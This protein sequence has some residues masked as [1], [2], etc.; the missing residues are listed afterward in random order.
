M[1]AL[2]ILRENWKPALTVTAVNVPLSISLAVASG[3]T[4]T[5]GIITGIWSTV[6]A[7]A[8]ASSRH[9]VFGVAGAL[10]SILLAFVLSHGSDGVALLPVLS[11]VSGLLI[12]LVSL[13]KLTRYVTLIPSTVLHGF[14]ISVGI[15]IALSQIS[16]A[17][18]LNDPALGIP[19][20]KEILLNLA[21]AFSH[22]GDSN[23]AAVATFAASLA[24][25]VAAKR[26]APAF[27][28]VVALTVA[29]IGA[30]MAFSKGMLPGDVLLL[31]EK[32]PDVAF[33]PF[34]FPFGTLGV[35]SFYGA[36]VLMKSVSSTAVVIAVVAILETVISA[37]IAEKM[38]RKKFD[39]DRE[40]LGL[41]LS[42]VGTG[43]LGGLPVTA[44]FIRTALNL[45]S[46][47]THR[48]SQ[49]LV[50]L[51]TFLAA[52]LLFE[53]FFQ[54]LPFPIIA[55]I[56]F[57][58]ALGLIDFSLLAKM[59]RMRRFAFAVMALTT[60]VSVLEDPTVGILLGTS[61]ALLAFIRGV[62]AGDAYVSVFRKGEF[63]R[64]TSL[65]DYV[66]DQTADDVIVVNFVGGLSYLNVEPL[67]ESVSRVDAGQTVLISFSHM[68]DLDVDGVEG[69]EE[70]V[71]SLE[72]HS[73]TVYFTGVTEKTR[74]PLAKAR[75]FLEM[76][77]D[78]RI[79][80]S[81]SSALADI[82]KPA[83]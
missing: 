53:G 21:E 51:F 54:Y 77:A 34:Q 12:L 81:T 38:T 41:G 73:V 48:A 64:K 11:I 14:L 23:P 25:L 58:I 39:R 63:H 44:V 28:S 22:L 18:G 79:R 31:S 57:N 82:L 50:G 68:G 17:L 26:F 45:K 7:A 46:G 56:L 75:F 10:S 37:K 6:I 83:S 35:D 55:A 60:V 3:A 1:N 80:P 4:P 49:G 69:L 59:Y 61:V 8:F 32:F 2:K 13:L 40:V 47:A 9:N 29:G 20:H 65:A 15:T 27:P 67:L 19:V 76:E 74:E 42:N 24:F 66:R 78:G 5:H 16:G 70:L 72:R 36:F 52:A 33:R 43:L 62:S 30:G 71:Q